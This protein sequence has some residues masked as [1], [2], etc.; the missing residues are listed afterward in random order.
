MLR[1]A[2]HKKDTKG[3]EVRK[4]ELWQTVRVQGTGETDQASAKSSRFSSSEINGMK[5]VSSPTMPGLQQ[6]NNEF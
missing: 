6:T 3:N 2:K 4:A 1:R 5:C